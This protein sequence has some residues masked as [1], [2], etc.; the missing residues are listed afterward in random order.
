LKSNLKRL[1]L[2]MA[3]DKPEE[4]RGLIRL[5]ENRLPAQMDWA[6]I[7]DNML[8]DANKVLGELKAAI[9]AEQL[10]RLIERHGK[11]RTQLKKLIAKPP[12]NEEGEEMTFEQRCE[13]M[14][15]WRES[16]QELWVEI[17]PL[18]E[19]QPQSLPIPGEGRCKVENIVVDPSELD[20]HEDGEIREQVRKELEAEIRGEAEYTSEDAYRHLHLCNGELYEYDRESSTQEMPGAPVYP[21]CYHY[22]CF[23]CG[24]RTYVTGD[25]SEMICG[26]D[27]AGQPL[28]AGM[29][30]R[31]VAEMCVC[32]DPEYRPG[33]QPDGDC[34]NPEC[35]EIAA[36]Y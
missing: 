10:R 20:C 22:I 17:E 4:E 21:P 12:D 32:G 16:M 3:G 23:R 19:F 13:R 29:T 8:V 7:P 31:E 30:T 1:K 14:T 18:R 34:M 26:V 15:Q 11:S 24:D 2:N 27:L 25:R 35:M 9:R 36:Q 33:G 5:P 28:Y 6:I